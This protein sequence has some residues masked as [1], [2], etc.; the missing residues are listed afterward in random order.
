MGISGL[1]ALAGIGLAFMLH[2]RDRPQADRLALSLE[3]VARAIENKYWVDELYDL[4]IVRP[5]RSAGRVFFGI[6]KYVV[7]GLVWITGFVPQF[8]GFV[9][10]LGLQ[11]GYVQGYALT[12]M[13]G[14]AV[15]LLFVFL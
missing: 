4:T 10:K 12:M 13:L 2:L 8:S 5:L 11:R 14:V 9:L 1:I 15:I 6:D 7:D 3:P